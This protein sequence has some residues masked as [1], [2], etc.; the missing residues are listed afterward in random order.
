MASLFRLALRL[1]R[2]P[3]GSAPDPS[4]L[5]PGG[6]SG[7]LSMLLGLGLGRPGVC[8]L[9]MLKCHP[10]SLALTFHPGGITGGAFREVIWG[11]GSG[12][13]WC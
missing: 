3:E 4:A 10:S 7:N 1:A 8:R 12:N 6:N 9:H 13:G 2:G 5:F 11:Y